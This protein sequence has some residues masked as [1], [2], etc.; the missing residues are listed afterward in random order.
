MAWGPQPGLEDLVPRLTGESSDAAAQVWV[1]NCFLPLPA[2][3]SLH[4]RS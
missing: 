4:G 1:V 2:S 3:H